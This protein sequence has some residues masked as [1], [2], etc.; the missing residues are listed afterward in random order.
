MPQSRGSTRREFIK[1]AMAAAVAPTLGFATQAAEKLS[2]ELPPLPY[3]YDALEPYID[4]E[5]MRLHHQKHHAA[6]ITGLAKAV[7]Q[8]PELRRKTL[9]ELLLSLSSLPESVRT[10]VRNHGGGHY[11]HS[12][13][14]QCLAPKAQASPEGPL[15]A[16]IA[17]DFG[18]F[19]SFKESFTKQAMA[20][21]GSGWA[22]LVW[23]AGKLRVETTPNQDTPLGVRKK[24][25]LGL[26]LWEHAYYLRYQWRRAE[27]IA[28]FWHV[29]NWP[30]VA[31]LFHNLVQRA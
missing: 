13:F 16:A 12:L 30:A 14:W 27:Y 25:I 4:A 1:V 6:Y 17:R 5:T 3:A 11:N 10:A 31:A 8:A 26:D 24:P 29:V 20:I 23:D 7:E 28:A 18:S 22:W 21:F 2:L 15:A 9:E 19:D